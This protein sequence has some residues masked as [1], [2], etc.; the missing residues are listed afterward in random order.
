MGINQERR[1]IIL[2]GY[3]NI[4]D[5]AKFLNCGYRKAK[6]I[7]E[8]LAEE[9]ENEGKNT[10]LGIHVKRLLDFLNLSKKQIL[11][12]AE[13]EDEQDKNRQSIISANN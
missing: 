3:A 10:T 6:K 12:Y 11:E 7:Y 9:A 8:A 1:K 2:K 5:T 13:I 4:S